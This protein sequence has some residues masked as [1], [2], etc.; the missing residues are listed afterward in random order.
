MTMP[1][2]KM[3]GL[4]FAAALVILFPATAR[5]AADDQKPSA[6]QTAEQDKKKAEEQKKAPKKQ[7]AGE[8]P[9]AAAPKPAP[10]SFTDD[11]LD[12]FH[13][14]P[15]ESADEAE[16]SEE[17]E[18]AT[19]PSGLPTSPPVQPGARPKVP[20]VATAPAKGPRP[21]TRP[22]VRPT[23]IAPPPQD[24][25]LK[26]FRDREAKEKFRTEQVQKMR[27]RLAAIDKRLEYLNAQKIGVLNPLVGMPAAQPGEDTQG[28]AALKPKELLEKIDLEIKGL[29]EEKEQVQADLVSIET[30]FSQEMQSR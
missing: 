2:G 8:K 12:R 4:T 27:D 28:Q 24:D 5:G 30:R 6:R 13:K 23:G 9:A 18:P 25:P 29:Q 17:D 3:A 21:V 16:S 15:A 26:P 1:S 11:D 22:V 14:P 10:L 19:V 20:P 7:Q